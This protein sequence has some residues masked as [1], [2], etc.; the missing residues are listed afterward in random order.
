MF[1]D[2]P[3]SVPARQGGA[4]NSPLAGS[5][6]QLQTV[7]QRFS[8]PFE[9]P[10]VFTQDLFG[11]RLRCLVFRD[12][13][14]PFGRWLA[15]RHLERLPQ[16]LNVLRGEMA[17]V[18]PRPETQDAVLR[19]QGSS[20]EYGRRFTVLPGITGLSQLSGC[21]DADPVGVGCRI[22]YDLYYVKH[23]SLILDLA[24]VVQTVE[25]VLWGK[26]AR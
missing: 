9:F 24:I 18:G 25:V 26:G 5:E 14:G 16:L 15:R 2:G 7:W 8:V 3:V 1:H 11:V 12:D 20:P 10:V 22:Q 17:L 6:V 21:A 19:W 23:R 4:M 13:L